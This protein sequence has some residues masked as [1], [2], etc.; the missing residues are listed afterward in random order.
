MSKNI[1]TVLRLFEANKFNSQSLA[2]HKCPQ[3]LNRS[4]IKLCKFKIVELQE[5]ID[6]FVQVTL[7][8]TKFI[9]IKPPKYKYTF[10]PKTAIRIRD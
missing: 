7:V 8:I 1:R 6:L 9:I 10:R 5:T 4:A 3:H 2:V